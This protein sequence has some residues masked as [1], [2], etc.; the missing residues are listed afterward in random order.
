MVLTEERRKN[1]VKG[2]SDKSSA[3]SRVDE[4]N[5]QVCWRRV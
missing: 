3:G 5:R 2:V 4:R 1:E